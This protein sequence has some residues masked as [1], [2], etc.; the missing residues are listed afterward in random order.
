VIRAAVALVALLAGCGYQLAG[1]GVGLP[2]GA[3]TVG[4]G[5][6][7]NQTR[8]HGLEV[9]LRRAIEEEFRRRSALDVVPDSE[10]DLVVTGTIRR[11]QTNPVGFIG[12][13]EA[14]QY[15]GIVQIGFRLKE[16]AT[17]RVLYE[18]RLLQE[19]LDFGA[20][21]DVVVSTSPRFQRGTIDVRDLANMTNVQIGEARRRETL[22]ELMDVLARDVYLQ[23]MEGF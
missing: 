3:R 17:G 20:V 13:S 16:R 22:N 5:L 12:T 14:V 8:E 9:A 18:N 4:I 15:Q 23:A 11:F 7:A 21:T 19:S 6:F 1:S 2:P 10:A